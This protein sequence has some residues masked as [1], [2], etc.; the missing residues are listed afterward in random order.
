M[1]AGLMN[2][3]AIFDAIDGP[4]VYRQESK[5]EENEPSKK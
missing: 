3:L 1:I 4:L 5:K 2:L